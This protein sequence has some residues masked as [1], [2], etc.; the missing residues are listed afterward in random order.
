MRNTTME[1]LQVPN[2]CRH[3]CCCVFHSDMKPDEGGDGDMGTLADHCC[4]L[5][6][7]G[8]GWLGDEVRT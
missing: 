1:S 4:L 3:H 7:G 8:P 5:W 2:P 6:L